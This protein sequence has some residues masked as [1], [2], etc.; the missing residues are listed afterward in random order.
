MAMSHRGI[1]KRLERILCV[2][3][4]ALKLYVLY[5]TWGRVQGFDAGGWLETFRVTHWFE[6]LPP[7]RSLLASYHPPLSY[8]LTRLIL[9]V[10]P[11]EAEASQVLSSFALLGA[12]F[13]LRMAL[14]KIGCLGSVVGLW[15]LYGGFSLPLFVWLA[16]ETGYDGLVLNWFMLALAVSISL[17]WWPVRGKYWLNVRTLAKLLALVA[18]LVAGLYTKYS[19]LLAF[20]LP[21][22]IIV[23]RRGLRAWAKESFLPLSVAL[24][25]LAIV[26]PFYYS[27]YYKVEH[28]WMP[29]AMEWQKNR[30]LTVTRAKRDAAPLDFVAHML[31]IPTES[32][33]DIQRPVMDSFVNSIWFHTWK[34]DKWLGKQPEPSL[35]VSNFYS[36]VFPDVLLVG[37]L[38]FLLKPRQGRR[39]WRHLG[40]LLLSITLMFSVA[41]LGFAWKYP[42]WGWRVCNAKYMAAAILWVAFATGMGFSQLSL[43]VRSSKVSRMLEWIAVGTLWVFVVV[44]HL[45]PVY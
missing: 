24:I 35:S 8:L 14:K 41:S 40:W 16:V 18:I 20:A 37:S 42:I 27:R 39:D 44:N 22:M 12:F 23:I 36:R 31:R 11:N 10:V 4:V 34:R 26:A 28:E 15:L 9:G 17:F 30:E 21:S 29:A 5:L 7:P 3:I 6:T 43:S 33:A 38:A 2:T 45:L 13:G 19:G 32:V 25:G 1:I